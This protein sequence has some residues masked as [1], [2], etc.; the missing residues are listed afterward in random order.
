MAPRCRGSGW[1]AAEA[2][3][4]AGRPTVGTDGHRWALRVSC[5]PVPPSPTPRWE[6]EGPER[7]RDPSP[8]ETARPL[9]VLTAGRGGG[10]GPGPGVGG[11]GGWGR[12]PATL[13]GCFR[14]TSV[15]C[16]CGPWR[17]KYLTSETSPSALWGF[18]GLYS[19]PHLTF[20]ETVN[21]T[22]AAW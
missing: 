20:T 13:V 19:S 18:A 3:A 4:A 8:G 21:M 6:Q 2:R 5:L 11:W 14:H 17:Q 9:G 15:S 7:G 1:R 16:V 12:P 10:V 22:A